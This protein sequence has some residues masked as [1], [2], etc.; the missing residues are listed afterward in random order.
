M[1]QRRYVEIF[2]KIALKAALQGARQARKYFQK[3][4][5][6]VSKVDRSPVTRADR[7]AEEV[8]RRILRREC[9]GHSVAGEEYG[10]TKGDGEFRWWIDPVD[11]TRQFVRGIPLWSTLLALEFRGEPLVGVIV[12]P[13]LSRAM[14]AGRG[15]GCFAD[16]AR[17]RVSRVPDLRRGTLTYGG[18][19]LFSKEKD[20]RLLALAGTAHDDRGYGDAFAH[21][22]VA[23]GQ[24]EA[25]VDPVVQP[26]DV[27]AVQVCVEEAG[28][29]F[30]DLSGRRTI[31]GG[32][33][34]SS[35]GSVHGKILEA[36][37]HPG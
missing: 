37:G 23:R 5:R 1:L 36:L 28:G 27:A 21:F 19:R 35:N 25:M 17:C 32:S 2:Q 20:R 11:G 24:V 10:E 14:W 30:T 7:E 4:I 26:Y 31:H 33:A 3:R 8:I 34:L 22:L 29:K 12:L 15:L 9:P 16:G 6:V 18:L 13:A